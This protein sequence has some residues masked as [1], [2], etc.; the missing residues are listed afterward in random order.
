MSGRKKPQ[1]PNTSSASEKP[2]AARVRGAGPFD[3][4]KRAQNQLQALEVKRQAVLDGLSDEAAVM[5]EA[6][7]ELRAK[8]SI[9]VMPIET[10][11]QT[12]AG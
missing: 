3:E 8:Q 4:A 10:P 5:L 7:E 2:T 9:A 12:T 11:E 1:E 6:L